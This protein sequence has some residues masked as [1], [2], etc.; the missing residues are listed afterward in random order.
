MASGPF[1]GGGGLFIFRDSSIENVNQL[2]NSDS[3][4][5]VNCFILEVYSFEFNF[6]G[7]C[8]YHEPLEMVPLSFIRF[9]EAKKTRIDKRISNLQHKFNKEV[10][11]SGVF[12]DG[13]GGFL[14]L[15]TEFEMVNK[16]LQPKKENQLV[17]LQILQLYIAKGNFCRKPNK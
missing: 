12:A 3:A 5:A 16:L 6:G 2:L 1:S 11:S 14:V 4:I 9:P 13:K 15:E 8:S 7:V 10:L 17:S